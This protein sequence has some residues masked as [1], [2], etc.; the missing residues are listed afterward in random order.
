[1]GGDLKGCF[2]LKKR[3]TDGTNPSG[4]DGRFFSDILTL[5]FATHDPGEI[6]CA[7]SRHFRDHD[8]MALSAESNL[9]IPLYSE[10]HGIFWV[11]YDAGQIKFTFSLENAVSVIAQND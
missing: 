9:P 8:A 11:V 2:I 3:G 7:I 10:C 1:M 4:N 6:K 5:Q